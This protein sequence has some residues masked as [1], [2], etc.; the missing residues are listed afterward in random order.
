MTCSS[1]EFITICLS[2]PSSQLTGVVSLDS[3]QRY[4]KLLALQENGDLTKEAMREAMVG[5]D[6]TFISST[7]SILR[8]VNS[9]NSV[10]SKLRTKDTDLPLL[11]LE[12]Y[13][14]E[15]S[16]T[17]QERLCHLSNLT[18]KFGTNADGLKQYSCNAYLCKY[19]LKSKWPNTTSDTT[20]IVPAVLSRPMLTA[21]NTAMTSIVQQLSSD[22]A[23]RV[24][25]AAAQHALL[26]SKWP[27]TTSDTTSIVP[28]VLSRPM[29]TANNTAMTSIVQQLS[30]DDAV[31]VAVAAAQHATAVAGNS[32]GQPAGFVDSRIGNLFVDSSTDNSTS[33]TTNH[34]YHYSSAPPPAPGVPPPQPAPSTPPAATLTVEDVQQM[35]DRQTETV[36]QTVQS[37]AANTEHIV[38]D[39]TQNQVKQV[40]Q[41]LTTQ[42]KPRS[43]SFSNRFSSSPHIATVE[44]VVQS[45]ATQKKPRSSSF[46]NCS[47][48]SP[49]IAANLGDR[50]EMK[51]P[52]RESPMQQ[53]QQQIRR[54]QS[55]PSAFL[56]KVFDRREGVSQQFQAIHNG[57]PMSCRNEILDSDTFQFPRA[58]VFSELEF[59]DHGPQ[60][61]SDNLL[62]GPDAEHPIG[63]AVVTTDSCRAAIILYADERYNDFDSEQVQDTAN[64][65]MPALGLYRQNLVTITLG[66]KYVE[67]GVM[68][69]SASAAE[70]MMTALLVAAA[71]IPDATMIQ[72]NGPGSEYAEGLSCCRRTMYK[73]LMAYPADNTTTLQFVL[74]DFI[75]EQ[76][77][78]LALSYNPLILDKCSFKNNG[79]DFAQA[80]VLRPN[81]QIKVRVCFLCAINFGGE[82]VM[83]LK[84]LQ[85]AVNNG[86]MAYLCFDNIDLK[87]QAELDALR[88]LCHAAFDKGWQV[89]LEEAVDFNQE[90]C[91]VLIDVVFGGTKTPGVHEYCTAR[92]EGDKVPL[93][94]SPVGPMTKKT[95]IEG[96]TKI[97]SGGSKQHENDNSQPP[98]PVHQRRSGRSAVKSSNLT[99]VKLKGVMVRHRMGWTGVV[100]GWTSSKLDVMKDEENVRHNVA[101]FERV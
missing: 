80:D 59:E 86:T 54:Y 10:S 98:S 91:L 68:F 84:N 82:T 97:F 45:L 58:I 49:D 35:M 15:A 85:C 61:L 73:F 29:L 33:N 41:S 62:L 7:Y 16:Q 26:R 51:S 39:A 52:D 44:Q 21:N 27:N 40:V 2:L 42:K 23:V 87:S 88:D 38:L 25:V 93:L 90:H 57:L 96:D 50:F 53:Q 13:P 92:V 28:A 14:S 63:T 18:R 99:N 75:E 48:S 94:V 60:L 5:A 4:L 9:I 74:V 20:S 70:Q 34:H 76:S 79:V 83:L 3:S 24:A 72:I 56:Q 32:D 8:F 78:P 67:I 95:A 71:G 100:M 65:G 55:H 89:L 77:T 37:S 66:E 46:S 1:E 36:I 64:P 6:N 22:D 12:E 11:L 69:S 81:K 30:S 43:S 101:D 31:R 19:L 47:S 17:Q